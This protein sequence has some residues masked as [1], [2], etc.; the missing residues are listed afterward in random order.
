MCMEQKES[1][2]KTFVIC[3][4]F[5]IGLGQVVC[6]DCCDQVHPSKSSKWNWEY[7]QQAENTS[8]ANLWYCH[9]GQPMSTSLLYGSG[10]V[11]SKASPYFIEGQVQV[12]RQLFFD[13][14]AKTSSSVVDITQDT[15]VPFLP[16]GTN[17][18]S[19]CS[20]CSCCNHCCH[21]LMM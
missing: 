14:S 18:I 4:S 11:Q 20:W 13:S 15:N 21:R 2:Q 6:P 8:V 1:C 5:S 17:S 9:Q 12:D 10:I 7:N 3:G 16:A 19:G